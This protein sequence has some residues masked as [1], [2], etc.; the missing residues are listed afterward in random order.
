M[1]RRFTLFLLCC[2]AALLLLNTHL[3]THADAIETKKIFLLDIKG[4]IG[5]ATSDYF[6]RGLNK[7]QQAGAEMVVIQ[8]DTP[9]GLDLAMRDMVQAII[10][11]AVP[12][13]TYVS[14]AGARAASAGTYILY[15][16][17]SANWRRWWRR[18]I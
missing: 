10:A 7:A 17:P 8:L 12:V 1:F 11:S 16:S 9:G 18:R 2:T 14:P 4:A 13:V 5:P 15:A 3:S 6:Q